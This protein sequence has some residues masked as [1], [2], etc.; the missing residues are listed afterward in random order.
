[1]KISKY[2]QAICSDVLQGHTDERQ[3]TRSAS[4][5]S[6]RVSPASPVP[7]LASTTEPLL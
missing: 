1:V 4:P 2:T 3:R 6:P 7:L 5:I